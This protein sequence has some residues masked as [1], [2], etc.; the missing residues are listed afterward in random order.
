M[1]KYNYQSYEDIPS[2]VE[3]YILTVTDAE[4]IHDVPLGDINDFMNGYE[5]WQNDPALRYSAATSGW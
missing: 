2:S 3:E 1:R 4:M 5:E